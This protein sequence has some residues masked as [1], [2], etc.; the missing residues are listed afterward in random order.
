MPTLTSEELRVQAALEQ[1]RVHICICGQTSRNSVRI[2]SHKPQF[3][4]RV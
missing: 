3:A 1:N 2:T 4:K